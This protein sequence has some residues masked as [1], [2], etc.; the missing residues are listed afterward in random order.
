MNPLN[1][2]TLAAS[3]ALGACV[4]QFG[5][6]KQPRSPQT[7]QSPSQPLVVFKEVQR[8]FTPEDLKLALSELRKRL[9]AELGATAEGYDPEASSITG[10][11]YVD[12]ENHEETFDQQK[13]F[14]YMSALLMM[15][16]QLE[17]RFS[18]PT[19]VSIGMKTVGSEVGLICSRV[20]ALGAKELKPRP[21]RKIKGI[22]SI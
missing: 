6:T 18:D 2:L 20:Q 16:L 4:P 3:L 8:D 9:L 21:T 7:Y 17:E 13:L 12:P 1:K 11:L 22:H 10:C 5:A 14:E 15:R 19:M